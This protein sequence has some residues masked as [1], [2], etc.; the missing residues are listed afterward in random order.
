MSN[1]DSKIE[2]VAATVPS[3]N[4]NNTDKE[5]MHMLLNEREEYP[6]VI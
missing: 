1:A 6:L 2:T 5:L 4:N 3:M